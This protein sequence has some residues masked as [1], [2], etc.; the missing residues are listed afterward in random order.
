MHKQSRDLIRHLQD[1]RLA[2]WSELEQSN[3][4]MEIHNKIILLD[5]ITCR[6]ILNNRKSQKKLIAL[7]Q[8]G[9][10]FL[11]DCNRKY[12]ELKKEIEAI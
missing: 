12:C 10:V 6:L 8:A 2:L 3:Y 1:V 9:F 7:V 11:A 5:E 4:Q